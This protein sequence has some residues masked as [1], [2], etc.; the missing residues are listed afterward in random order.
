[1]KSKNEKDGEEEDDASLRIQAIKEEDLLL[2]SPHGFGN[3][4]DVKAAINK[5]LLNVML[6]EPGCMLAF[7]TEAYM[8]STGFVMLQVDARH[9]RTLR[10][11]EE[12]DSYSYMHCYHFESLA[13]TVREFRTLKMLE[14]S[15]MAPIIL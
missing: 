5:N 4:T 7:V 12:E 13:T 3:I 1:M 9:T 6:S 10:K 8:R 2:L 15:K 11:L 14:F